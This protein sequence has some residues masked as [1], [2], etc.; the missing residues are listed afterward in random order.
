MCLAYI[1]SLIS[2][3]LLIYIIQVNYNEE[4]Y[5]RWGHRWGRGWGHRNYRVP[6]WN[7]VA[8]WR[9]YGNYPAYSGYWRQCPK[10]GRWCPPY[11]S[12]ANPECQ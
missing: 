5:P 4:F 9:P 12:C 1:V 6:L 3:I 8:N 11:I 2:I 7:G 10:S